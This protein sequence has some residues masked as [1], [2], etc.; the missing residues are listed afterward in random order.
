[1][2]ENKKSLGRLILDGLWGENPALRLG[3]G[4]CPAIAV[5]TTGYRGLAMGLATAAVL[6]CSNLLIALVGRLFEGNARIPAFMVLIAGL[7]VAAGQVLNAYYPELTASMG[8]YVPLIAANTLLLS[9]AEN[10]AAENGPV[11]AV[12]DGIGM[13]LGYVCA[14][15]VLGVARELFGFGTAFGQVVF[16]G[17]FDGNALALLPAGGFLLLGLAMGI[18]NAAV[19]KRSNGKEDATT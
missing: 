9:R 15:T 4:L 14:L 19:G 12:A 1:M 17:N 8:M 7:A 2:A 5:T 16:A 13:G 6:L 3:L 10:L 11:A 18:F